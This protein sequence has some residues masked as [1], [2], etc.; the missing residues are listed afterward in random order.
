MT[1]QAAKVKDRMLQMDSCI[2][3][4]DPA[5]GMKEERWR[6]AVP[7]KRRQILLNLSL[8][9]ISGGH[10]GRKHTTKRWLETFGGPHSART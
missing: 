1:L 2:M 5:T 4:I 9:S 8:S 10:L 7:A 3:C 6:I